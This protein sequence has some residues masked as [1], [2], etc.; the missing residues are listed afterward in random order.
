V[1]NARTAALRLLGR[2]DYTSAEIRQKL[3]EREYAEDE[4]ESALASLRAERLVDDRRAAAAYVR[5]A[6]AIK[7]RGRHRIA[8][9]LEAR[10]LARDVVNETLS[11]LPEADEVAAIERFLRRR[12]LPARLSGPDRQKVFQQ[13]LRR[14]FSADLIA[15]AVRAREQGE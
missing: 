1:P 10:G 2:R 5:N 15:K 7:G 3:L 6:T 11:E 13:L 8:R 9:E 14:G 12:S 4:V